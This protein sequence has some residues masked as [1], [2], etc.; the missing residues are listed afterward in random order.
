MLFMTAANLV[1]L[2]LYFIYQ[3]CTENNNSSN[4]DNDPRA[5][6]GIIAYLLY[7]ITQYIIFK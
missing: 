5:F 1:P 2:V 4:N 7:I 6:I 3:V